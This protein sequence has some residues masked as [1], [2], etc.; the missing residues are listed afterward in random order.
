MNNPILICLTMM[1][2]MLNRQ[3]F[4]LFNKLKQVK[5]N[6]KKNLMEIRKPLCL[7]HGTK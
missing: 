1:Q 6:Q 5:I 4:P 7:D 3:Q 2:Q